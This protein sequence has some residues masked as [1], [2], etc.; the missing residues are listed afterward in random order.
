MHA[1]IALEVSK[2][3]LRWKIADLARKVRV[4]RPLIYYHFGKTKKGILE[5]SLDLVAEE[6]FGLTPERLQMLKSGRAEE[7]LLISRK[8]FLDE[9]AFALFYLKWRMQ[10][11]PLQERLIEIEKRYQKTLQE[12]FPKMKP[13]EVRALHGILY[14]VVTAP[15]LDEEAIKGILKMIKSSIPQA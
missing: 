13:A 6:F 12:H 2:G 7:T 5:K 15:F 8:L 4:S 14:A 9:P 3:H 11:S 10:K 1:V